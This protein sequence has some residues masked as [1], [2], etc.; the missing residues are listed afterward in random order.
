MNKTSCT[1]ADDWYEWGADERQD[2]ADDVA[3]FYRITPNEVTEDMIDEY[4]D[5][6][7]NDDI[8]EFIDI[9]RTN[10]ASHKIIAIEKTS[11]RMYSFIESI[12]DLRLLLG[13][14]NKIYV[15]YGHLYIEA[16]TSNSTNYYELKVL[17]KIG[18]QLK[19]KD[20]GN[21][22]TGKTYNSIINSRLFTAKE[23]KL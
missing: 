3:R 14:N 13:D 4:I 15:E 1:F 11:S 10:I 18:E 8:E 5:N 17:T 22:T 21:N 12:P 7:K 9:M 23:L 6:Y 19:E 20:S 16:T 2:A